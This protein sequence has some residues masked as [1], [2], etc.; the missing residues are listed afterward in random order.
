MRTN[1]TEVGPEAPLTHGRVTWV[2]S[3]GAV[4]CLVRVSASVVFLA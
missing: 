4:S 3:S 2:R 1:E